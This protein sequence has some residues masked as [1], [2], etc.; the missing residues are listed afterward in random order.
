MINT[1]FIAMVL[2]GCYLLPN[3]L[4][5]KERISSQGSSWAGCRPNTFLLENELSPEEK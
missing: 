4:H 5:I 3:P 1:Q 2:L